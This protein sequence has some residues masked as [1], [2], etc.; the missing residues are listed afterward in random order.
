M[1]AENKK[2][3][4]PIASEDKLGVV[5]SSNEDNKVSIMTDGSMK[6]NNI[7]IDSIK[8]ED[9]EV[10]ILNGGSATEGV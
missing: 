3:N 7:T 2:S 1:Q 8:Q 4:I 6:I 10:F 9:N 5:L